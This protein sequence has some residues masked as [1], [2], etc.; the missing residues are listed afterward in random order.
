MQ[1]SKKCLTMF[2]YVKLLVGL[3]K[4]YTKIYLGVISND[5]ARSKNSKTLSVGEDIVNYIF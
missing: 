4:T 1:H 5:N 3:L 2:Y